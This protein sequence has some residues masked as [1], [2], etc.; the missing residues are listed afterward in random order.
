MSRPS[1]RGA[2]RRLATLV[3]LCLFVVPGCTSTKM[4]DT[5][6]APDLAPADLD[7]EKVVAIAIFPEESRRRIAEDTLAAAAQRVPVTAAYR[8]LSP[9]DRADVERL[10]T[11]VEANGFDGAVVVRLVGQTQTERWVPGTYSGGFYGYYGGYAGRVY[12]PGYMVTDTR[13]QIETSLHD[14]QTGRLLWSGVSETLNPT[15]VETT[16]DEVAA[17]TS[18][19]LREE[20]LLQ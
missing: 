8:V 4:V 7:F 14:V 2:A 12:D 13:V 11:A 18:K 9:E 15:K 5:W 16:I 1:R 20:G 19:A 6:K 10:R 3:S 17:A